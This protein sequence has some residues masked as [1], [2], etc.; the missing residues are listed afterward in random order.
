MPPERADIIAGGALVVQAVAEAT[1]ARSLLV[2]GQ[3]L[4][5]GVAYEAF[6]VGKSPVVRDARGAG[7]DTF[8]ERYVTGA[9]RQFTHEDPAPLDER[10]TSTVLGPHPSDGV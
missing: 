9:L 5:E 7:V 6:R 10:V 4:R 8:R 2:C 1:G 3:G